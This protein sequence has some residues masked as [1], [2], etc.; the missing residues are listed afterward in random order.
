MSLKGSKRE[1][2]CMRICTMSS[3]SRPSSINVPMF[4][5]SK[6][7]KAGNRETRETSKLNRTIRSLVSLANQDID[8]D[9][10]EEINSQLVYYS[11][12]KIKLLELKD[13][14]EEQH[15]AWK[16]I[17]DKKGSIVFP[18]SRVGGSLD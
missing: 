18:F 1:W 2:I 17:A 16:K 4:A 3:P 15:V 13:Q 9:I 5:W 8:E 14:I 11:Q 10:Q 6:Q 7:W 12:Q